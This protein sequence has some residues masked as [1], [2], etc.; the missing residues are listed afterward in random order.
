[1]SGIYKSLNVQ[2]EITSSMSEVKPSWINIWSMSSFPADIEEIL[3]DF[4]QI[5]CNPGDNSTVIYWSFC[6]T[7]TALRPASRCKVP[8]V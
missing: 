5:E 7:K 6:W 2:V 1:M 3:A 8:V 4:Y